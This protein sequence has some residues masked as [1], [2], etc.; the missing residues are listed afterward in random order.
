M[1]TPS[2]DYAIGLA[3]VRLAHAGQWDAALELVECAPE[4]LARDSTLAEV[5]VDRDWW[6]NGIERPRTDAAVAAIAEASP[7]RARLLTVQLMW[8]DTV[9]SIIAGGSPPD[10]AEAAAELESLL[11]GAPSEVERARVRFL[12]GL[13]QEKLLGQRELAEETYRAT[14]DEAED[15]IAAHALRH[16]G[17]LARMRGD[18]V[19]A[20]QLAHEAMTR[21]MAVGHIPGVLA[22]APLVEPDDRIRAFTALWGQWM[23]A[24][25]LPQMGPDQR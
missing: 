7:W 3:A 13:V 16:L 18:L 4:G 22:Q 24:T 1:T 11:A 14:L 15:F 5:L 12:L 19:E 25:F 2:L 10:G 23:G 8:N 6:M 17:D 9:R 20:R 21:R